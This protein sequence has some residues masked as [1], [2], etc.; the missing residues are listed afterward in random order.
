MSAVGAAVMIAVN[1][2]L[3]P[4]IGY[5]ACA[6]GGFAGY[7]V[8]MVM[9]FFIGQKKYPIAYDLKRIGAFVLLA[10]VL[11]LI[12]RFAF[13]SL[14]TAIKLCIDTVLLAIF[15]AAIYLDIKKR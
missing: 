7:G 11:Y 14:Q 3:V 2:L 5:Y 13:A 12:S 4:S 15:C 6:W 9:S 8:A 10:S 1:V